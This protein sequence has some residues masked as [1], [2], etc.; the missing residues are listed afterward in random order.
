MGGGAVP[1]LHVLHSQ[2]LDSHKLEIITNPN[3]N[4]NRSPNRACQTRA[5]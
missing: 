5:S 3:P 1:W 4:R 2:D